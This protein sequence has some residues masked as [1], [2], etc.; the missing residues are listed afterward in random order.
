[1]FAN[2]FNISS[3]NSDNLLLLYIS[4]IFS[5]KNILFKIQNIKI[6]PRTF[7]VLQSHTNPFYLAILLLIFDAILQRCHF[8]F[9][10]L[11]FLF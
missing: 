6:L 5:Y 2:L 10:L 1:M 11:K 8:L 3:L 4:P 7:P 9:L